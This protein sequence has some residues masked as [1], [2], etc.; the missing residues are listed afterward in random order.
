MLA[1]RVWVSTGA[2]RSAARLRALSMGKASR[3]SRD[4]ALN[5]AARRIE[6]PEIL[7]DDDMPEDDIAEPEPESERDPPIILPGTPAQAAE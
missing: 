3:T 1:L 4:L 6:S 5:A 2:Y 7:W